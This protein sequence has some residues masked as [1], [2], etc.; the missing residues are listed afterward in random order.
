MLKQLLCLAKMLCRPGELLYNTALSLCNVLQFC[1]CRICQ[2]FG[3]KGP[4]PSQKVKRVLIIHSDLIQM[5]H[6]VIATG[7]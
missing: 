7:D 2:E 3:T 4:E 5:H 1:H 6:K